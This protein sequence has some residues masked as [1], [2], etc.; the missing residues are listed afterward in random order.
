MTVVMAGVAVIVTVVLPKILK[1]H[2]AQ[3]MSMGGKQ[4]TTPAL[5]HLPNNTQA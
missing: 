1:G 5:E 3:I 4:A 2:R